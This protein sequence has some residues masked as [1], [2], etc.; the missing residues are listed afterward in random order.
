MHQQELHQRGMI[1]NAHSGSAQAM[2][3]H[4]SPRAHLFSRRLSE[5]ETGQASITDM[6][7]L[8]K[9]TSFL[10]P[11]SDCMAT[12]ILS[13]LLLA[14]GGGG[15]SGSGGGFAR[16]KNHPPLRLASPWGSPAG[17]PARVGEQG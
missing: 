9:S 11:K 1:I 8:A 7:M 12:S 2:V 5:V 10:F 6:R 16:R 14:G 15:H 3:H 13:E 17:L 4:G